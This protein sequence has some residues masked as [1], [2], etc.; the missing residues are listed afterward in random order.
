M[1]VDVY[2]TS[3]GHLA[4]L[5]EFLDFHESPT[6]IVDCSSPETEASNRPCLIYYNPRYREWIRHYSESKSE[7][8]GVDRDTSFKHFAEDTTLW[9]SL[10]H[11]KTSNVIY[12]DSIW[13]P[14]RVGGRWGILQMSSPFNDSPCLDKNQWKRPRKRARALS[15]DETSST[16]SR[17]LEPGSDPHRFLPSPDPSSGTPASEKPTH[18][19]DWTRYDIP[20][21]SEFVKWLR[22]Y[23]WGV[24]RI[25]PLEHWSTVLRQ[26]MFF[27]VSNPEPRCIYIGHDNST[28]M[29]NEACSKL[30]GSLHPEAMG[31][32]GAVWAG[33]AWE[34]KY[35]GIKQVLE[36]GVANREYNHYY[37]IPRED[38]PL[39]EAYFSSCTM[40]II[41]GNGNIFG[42]VKEFYE[43]T[44][45]VIENRRRGTIQKVEN[46]YPTD[47]I[48]MFWPQVHEVIDSNPQ[49]FPFCLIYS[50]PRDS[51]PEKLGLASI[52]GTVPG[53]FNLEGTVGLQEDHTMVI[54]RL[55]VG[56]SDYPLSK[57]FR[58]AWITR[59]P[60]I[61]TVRDGNLP[62]ALQTAVDKRGFGSTC[63]SVV[64]YPINRVDGPGAVGFLLL[65]LNPQRHYDTPYKE[66][67]KSLVNQFMKSAAS[68]LVPSERERLLQARRE[69]E[70]Q[71]REFTKLAELA[72]VGCAI[73]ETDRTIKYSNPIFNSLSTLRSRKD[74]PFSE[75]IPIHP[76]DQALVEN[77]YA[78][79]FSPSAPENVM[80]FEFRVR[81]AW[82]LPEDVNS[83]HQWR[84]LLANSSLIPSSI[85]D[86]A[87]GD[88]ASVITYLMDITPEKREQRKKLEDAMETKRQSDDF[89]DMVRS[90]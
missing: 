49:D 15:M 51:R 85:E 35:R 41:D 76:H 12:L 80:T 75:C 24:T 29:Y 38:L 83:H 28:M 82:S 13:V 31:V 57:E 86:G 74:L 32:S 89:I 3:S 71:E 50:T 39:M 69:A 25:G 67:L 78:R 30:L 63:H 8:E 90:T 34:Y 61:L 87:N 60:V 68:I 56:N 73:F 11:G 21:S 4:L 36:T 47:S 72:P 1:A 54:D 79:L 52:E 22:Q 6:V 17:A 45:T 58:T 40:P 23:N 66:F 81:K 64:L 2:S 46:M 55:D 37:P 77:K 48:G 16:S 43:T 84:C 70:A 9:D 20:G 27:I 65:G 14:C 10:I 19:V 33:P 88:A 7:I 62:D 42:V 59:R 44:T 53:P 18:L 5:R 26:I